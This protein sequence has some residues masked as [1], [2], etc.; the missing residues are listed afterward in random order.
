MSR[1]RWLVYGTTRAHAQLT[2]PHVLLHHVR[3]LIV[4]QLWEYVTLMYMSHLHNAMMSLWQINGSLVLFVSTTSMRCH[5][6]RLHRLWQHWPFVLH[7]TH[8]GVLDCAFSSL[9]YSYA[10]PCA[11][12]LWALVTVLRLEVAPI[13]TGRIGIEAHALWNK[14]LCS[15]SLS[16]S[17]CFI[18]GDG[19]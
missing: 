5:V 16:V 6:C 13:V 2:W 14:L 15:I 1:S 11:C 17:Y 18:P 10:A 8:S 19:S 7:C 9:V 12:C 3:G 4:V